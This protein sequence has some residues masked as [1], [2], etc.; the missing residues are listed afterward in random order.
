MLR[1]SSFGFS[2]TAHLLRHRKVRTDDAIVRLSMAV[3]A[4]Y[5]RVGGGEQRFDFVHCSFRSW[6]Q[7]M[8][9]PRARRVNKKPPLTCRRMKTELRTEPSNLARFC[10]RNPPRLSQEGS[11]TS[12]KPFQQ[13]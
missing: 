13:Q 6:L 9:L 10:M 11:A 4:A 7:D 12:F 2:W 3:A 1:S 5:S 8:T